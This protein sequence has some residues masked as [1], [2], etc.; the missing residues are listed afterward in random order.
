MAIKGG[1]G[2]DLDDGFGATG[3]GGKGTGRAEEG[4]LDLLEG[5]FYA[6]EPRGISRNTKIKQEGLLSITRT[7]KKKSKRVK[8]DRRAR[9]VC[10]R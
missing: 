9:L 8:G 10:Y 1:G 7:Q 3:R 5:R 4:G 6:L 2:G